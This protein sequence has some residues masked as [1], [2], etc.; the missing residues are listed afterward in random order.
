MKV[1]KALVPAADPGK[2]NLQVNGSTQLAD[3]IDGGTTGFVNVAVGSNPTV[4]ELAGTGTSLADYESSIACTGASSAVASSAGPLAVGVLTAGQQATCTITNKRKPQLRVIKSLVPSSDTGRFDLKIDATTFTNSGAGYGDG[5]DTG[6]VN[7]YTGSHTVS[8]IAHGST[9]LANYSQV[10][11]CDNGNTNAPGGGVSLA[12]AVLAYGAKVTC[13]IVNTFAVPTVTNNKPSQ[14]VQYSDPIA[15]VT[16]TAIDL[17]TPGSGLTASTAYTK[18]GGP[19]TAGLPGPLTL[20]I[21]TTGAHTRTWTL[22]GNA[23]IQ[24]ATYVI[25]VTVSDGDGHSGFTS[26]TLIA[27]KEDARA[28]YTGDMLAFTPSGGGNANVLLRA[29][30]QDIT[31]ADPNASPPNPDNYPGVITN[32]TATLMVNGAAPTGC[33]NLP[34]TLIGADTKVGSVNCSTSLGVGA[35]DISVT[36][37]NYYTYGDP[38]PVAIGVVEVAQPD[39]SFITGG[40]YILIASSSPNSAGQYA[41]DPGSR[42]NY[43]FNVKYNKNQTNTQG[44]INI[45]FRRTVGGVVRTYQIKTTAMD[46]LGTSLKTNGTGPACPGPPSSTCWGLA[47]FRSKANLTDVTNPLAPFPSAAAFAADDAHRQGRAGLERFDRYHALGRKHASVLEPLER[48]AD[49]GEGHRWRQPRRPLATDR[50]ESMRG[51]ARRPL[52]IRPARVR[53]R[54][55]AGGRRGS[56]ARA[57]RRRASLRQRRPRHPTPYRRRRRGA[58]ARPRGAPPPDP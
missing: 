16:V 35:Y 31:A 54:L 33:S 23:L 45:I 24:P 28:F 47:D 49:A 10:I 40:G 22:T 4:G 29:T 32:A 58:R 8:E 46:S 9:V 30:V 25:T 17:D 20:G 14:S 11:S 5:G 48:G 55:E 37:N 56:R 21:A 43:G 50:A 38:T 39:G 19:S 13:T 42:T 52:A 41:A 34:V 1:V 27:T 57:R 6:F 53:L 3:A 2:F 36:V 7:V 18:N 44:H 15:P 12:T 26:F 51:A